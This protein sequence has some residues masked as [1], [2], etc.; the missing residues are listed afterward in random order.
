MRGLILI[1]VIN[2]IGCSDKK[3]PT[4]STVEQ[5]SIALL[6]IKNTQLAPPQIAVDSILFKDAATVKLTFEYDGAD[7][8]YS[9]N[10]S[11]FRTYNEVLIIDKTSS[12]KVKSTKAGYLES[13]EQILNV[14]KVS[15][16]TNQATIQVD[17]MP[18][19]QYLGNAPQS[20]IDGKKG[21]LN[22]RNGQ[23]WSGFQTNEVTFQIDFEKPTDIQKV[24]CSLLR[25]HNSWIFLPATITVYGDNKTK[26]VNRCQLSN[27]EL[28]PSL[29]FLKINVVEAKYE[30]ITIKIQNHPSIP[31]W[32]PGKGTT[33]W[34]FIDEILID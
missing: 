5:D 26:G 1:L 24:T 22:F 29:E 8:L 20:F 9:I 11:K 4:I 2:V 31:E 21:T 12:I 15:D 28:T 30:N 13:D 7:I 19:D 18:S 34:L 33:P 6:Q 27:S 3:L 23:Q 32:H 16:K 17:P 25:D 10:N 14:V